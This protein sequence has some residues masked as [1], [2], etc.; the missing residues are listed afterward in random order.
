MHPLPRVDEI[1][2]DFDNDERALYWTQVKMGVL[3]RAEL[4]KLVL[5]K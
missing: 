3:A 2:H 4:L 5:S 1:D